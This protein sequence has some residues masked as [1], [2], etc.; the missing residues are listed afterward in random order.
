MCDTF[1][2]VRFTNEGSNLMKRMVGVG[3]IAIVLAA[4]LSI[5]PSRPQDASSGGGWRQGI[6]ADAM[7]ELLRC[8]HQQR[9]EQECFARLSEAV[10]RDQGQQARRT[11]QAAPYR[12]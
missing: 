2:R 3:F 8:S 7:R 11:G 5:A 1:S 6:A 4:A 12:T 9:G 10:A